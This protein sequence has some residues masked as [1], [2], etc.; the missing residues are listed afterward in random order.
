MN[1][2]SFTEAATLTRY[3]GNKAEFAVAESGRL[4]D[5]VFESPRDCE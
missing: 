2:L 4:I 3:Y 1:C 5:T